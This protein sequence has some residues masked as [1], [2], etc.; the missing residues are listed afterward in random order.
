MRVF[1]H[2]VNLDPIL[3]F[4][5]GFLGFACGSEVP[6]KVEKFWAGALLAGLVAWKAQRS[7][8]RDTPIASA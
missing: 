4:L 6:T 2:R 7:K 8:P 1:G 3:Y 5:I